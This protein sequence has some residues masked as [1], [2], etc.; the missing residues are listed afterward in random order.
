MSYSAN[1]LSADF[2]TGGVLFRRVIAWLIDLV[3]IAVLVWA[4]WWVLALFGLLTLGFGFGAMAILP[5]VPFL[6]NILSLL[7]LASATPG[8]QIMGLTV[9]RSHDLGPPGPMQALI[10]VLLYYLTLATSGL[11][12]LVA[13]F[14]LGHR[15]LHDLL[16]GLVVVR[17]DAMEALTA[18]RGI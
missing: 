1:A 8:Q 5:W 11:L 14:T 6:Y 3:L 2:L 16:T 10:Y 9:R 15:T 13:L 17:I 7:S 12:L 4:L 18:P